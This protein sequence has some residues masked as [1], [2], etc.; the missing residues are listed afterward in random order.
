MAV[1][2]GSAK[3]K[4]DREDDRPPKKVV[5]SLGDAHPKK[6]TPKPGHGASK[7]MMTST[8]PVI[9]GPRHLFTHK[10]YVVRKCNPS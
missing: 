7:W 3:R 9:E 4:V 6:S 1:F 2:K 10:D 5:I 8:G